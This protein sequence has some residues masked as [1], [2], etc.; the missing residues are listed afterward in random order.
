MEISLGS[1]SIAT[2]ANN[3]AV[4]FGENSFHGWKTRS[5]K[6]A[7]LKRISGDWNSIAS[8]VNYLNDSDVLDVVVKTK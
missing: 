5:K 6:N 7:A 4:F 2:V 8:I 3:A 1:V